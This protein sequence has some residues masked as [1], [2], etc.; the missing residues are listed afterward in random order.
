MNGPRA[1]GDSLEPSPQLLEILEGYLDELE[2]GRRPNPDELLA[3]HPDL[4]EPLRGCLASLEFLSANSQAANPKSEIRNP[5]QIQSTKSQIQNQAER[6]SNIGDSDLGF[7]SDFGFRASD[8]TTDVADL[9]RIAAAWAAP[10]PKKKG[11]KAK[12][13][14][15]ALRAIL[16]RLKSEDATTRYPTASAILEALAQAADYVPDNPDAWG[17]L[18]SHIRDT[19]KEDTPLKQ[20]A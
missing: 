7:V 9:S 15:K 17:K 2:R 6:A 10:S 4:A 3:R 19:G 20:S 18:L 16:E 5:K 13:F 8:F 14:P 1:L 12:P 11:G